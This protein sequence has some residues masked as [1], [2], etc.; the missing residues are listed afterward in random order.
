MSPEQAL[1]VVDHAVEAS[2]RKQ[3]SKA[4]DDVALVTVETLQ[5]V[6]EGLADGEL[7]AL[8][9]RNKCTGAA[10]LTRVAT[11]T[12]PSGRQP[13]RLSDDC[14][15]SRSRYGLMRGFGRR[16]RDKSEAR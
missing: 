2:M 7:R 12:L 14:K 4:E 15:V 13:V 3:A 10:R 8:W 5:E 16:R 1:E 11:S 6:R 9:R